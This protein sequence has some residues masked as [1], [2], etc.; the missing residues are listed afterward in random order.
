MS[1]VISYLRFHKICMICI[2]LTRCIRIVKYLYTHRW[3]YTCQIYSQSIHIWITYN[4]VHISRIFLELSI[5]I[6][7]IL[8]IYLICYDLT[9][10]YLQIGKVPSILES[11]RLGL[12]INV[13]L[14]FI[15]HPL[16]AYHVQTSISFTLYLYQTRIWLE[17]TTY[18]T[19]RFLYTSRFRRYQ[20]YTKT[21]FI[22]LY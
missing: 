1:A 3:M 2:N 11:R 18:S 5:I 19:S 9:I 4:Y 20:E 8:Y 16:H 7:I 21:N 13:L 17:S 14:I 22:L 15:R 12:T 6:I 10:K